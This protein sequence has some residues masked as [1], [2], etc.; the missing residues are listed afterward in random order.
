MNRKRIAILTAQADGHTQ[1]RFLEGFF[2]KARELD[3]DVC[4][5]SMYLK[6][7]DTPGREIGESNIYNLIDFS[8]FDGV[9]LFSDR[10]R[11][12]GVAEGLVWRV[13][14]EFS[15]PV[16][17]MND[18]EE[19]F[20]S[21][22]IDHRANVAMLTDHLIEVHGCKDIVMVNGWKDS[23]S[24]QVKEAGFRD[25]MT[26][27]GLTVSDDDIYYGNYWYDSGK[28][29]AEFLIEERSILPEAV[30]CANDYMA[31]GLAGELEK[32]GV[33]VPEDVAV[34]GYDTAPKNDERIVP[35]TSMD[36]PAKEDGIFTAE[37]IDSKIKGKDIEISKN[38]ARIHWGRSCGCD[39]CRVNQAE[40]Q[41][42]W[43]IDPDVGAYRSY[44]DHMAEDLLSQTDYRGFYNTV[45]Q[46]IHSEDGFESF[47]LCLNEYWQ[48]PEVM[49]GAG[50]LKVG[51]TRNVYRVIKCENNGS[52]ANAVDFD[53]CF[54]V[55]KLLPELEEDREEPDA[56]LFTP[57]YFDDRC[58]G[59]AAISYGKA[60]RGYHT[61]YCTWV[62]Q[63]M[64]SMEAFYRQASLQKLLDK[65]N[66]S[67][68]RDDLTG[69]YNY[70]GFVGKCKKM[71][72]DAVA[73]GGK[74]MLLS[75][76]MRGLKKINTELGRRSGD[77]AIQ[78]LALMI[79]SSIA[80]SD[81]SMRMGADEFMVASQ[82]RD[83]DSD[84]AKRIIDKLSSKI[85]E[86]N[87][88][89]ADG[90]SID[91]FHEY[92]I[93][94]ITSSESLDSY[95][96]NLVNRKN[97]TK[98]K[99]YVLNKEK[100]EVSE[101]DLEQ[102]RIVADILD[103]NS[104]TY[105]FQ[106]IVN[107]RT[108]QIY[109]YEVLMRPI[110]S[111]RKISPLDVISS[112]ARLGRLV[113]VER[114]TFFNVLD[115]VDKKSKELEGKKIFLN[116]IPGCNMSQ[117][118]TLVIEDKMRRHGGQVVV[119]FTE[120][121]EMDD[122]HLKGIKDKYLHMNIDTAIDD[123]GAGYSNVN[124][125]LRYMPKYV[126][127]DR[128]LMTNIHED[129]QKQHFVKDIIEFAHDN[130]IITL[131]EGVE[132]EEELREVIRLGVDLVQGY[133]T[134]KPSP[135]A[136]QEIDR[137][138]VTE[139]VQ[140]NQN[141][142]TRYGKKTYV[143]TDEDSISMVQMAFNKYTEIDFRKVGDA[144]RYI[145]MTGTPGFKSNM[146]LTISDGFRGELR[147]SNISL[148]GDKGLPCIKIGENCDVKIVLFGYNELRTGGIQVPES[149][150]FE[151]AGDGDLKITLNCGKYFG[152][153]NDFSSRHGD[154]FFNQD[155][156]LSIT[157]NGMRGIGI[158]SGYG[159]NI[160]ISHGRYEIDQRGQEG[161][162]I[163]CVDN[164]CDLFVE[165]CDMEIYNGVANSVTIG[166]YNGNA[167]IRIENISGNIS[168]ACLSATVIG[169]L[170]G[171]NCKVSLKNVNITMNIRSS[172]CYGIG[173]RDAATDIDVQHAYVKVITQG[174]NAYA[175]GN[176]TH[177]AKVQISNSD[178]NTEV[179]NSI[180]TDIGAEESNIKIGNGRISFMV[181][182]EMVDRE[183]EIVDL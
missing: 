130:D 97:T 93:E 153:G 47:N 62:K 138:V 120:E 33:R 59:Y 39:S 31:I 180:G 86:F 55:G 13:K 11:T 40:S 131:A 58:F 27:H 169:T 182:G 68:I 77:E 48:S 23:P 167:N 155:G 1:S 117:A 141:E 159:G 140:F 143:I 14:Q 54:E 168:G 42:R 22:S 181:N 136:I 175:M 108:G 84:Y 91:I 4:V 174:K 158:G 26:R 5:F 150:R 154:L 78:S 98:A 102:D 19:G 17:V 36:I 82:V 134:A 163:G 109:A 57:V 111:E 177:T 3:Y 94:D 156:T 104:L 112:A 95:I 34:V 21:F 44:Y 64:K 89:N 146:L 114:A 147:I 12:P 7:Q 142:I 148:G 145:E 96:N 127:I 133:Y 83:V 170:S 178:V 45:F 72:E 137:R 65:L 126:K 160:Y 129:Q 41:F 16:L 101:A 124:N 79:N 115:I 61:N 38:T 52:G 119:E 106:P 74:M 46:C 110:C 87:K 122:A 32:R 166:S 49:I 128:M 161:V 63:V 107:A 157:A 99:Q 123:Y 113:D 164:D 20:D 135:E 28:G 139:I 85:E 172:E 92:I 171:E 18:E 75:L 173:S 2:E 25:S 149:S 67:Q 30:V 90:F 60:N 35:L 179:T 51:Y 116:S 183:I 176:A 29:V 56:Y 162:V 105:Y 88:T 144:Y 151:L 80:S 8:K 66:A 9:I 53:N 15:G 71:C 165:C 24:S 152:I 81:V 69:M 37:L 6:Y 10:I 50:A 100:S 70:N 73:K 132:L 43:S 125:L 118:D 121:A 103:N 76:D